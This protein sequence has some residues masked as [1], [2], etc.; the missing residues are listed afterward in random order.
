MHS[1]LVEAPQRIGQHPASRVNELSPRL[2]KQHVAVRP[3][4]SAS[5]TLAVSARRAGLSIYTAAP[6]SASLTCTCTSSRP[7][8][9]SSTRYATQ[10]HTLPGKQRRAIGGVRWP[11]PTHPSTRTHRPA[12]PSPTRLRHSTRRIHR[13]GVLQDKFAHFRGLPP[14]RAP[15]GGISA[16]GWSHCALAFS[17][18]APAPT[19][20]SRLSTACQ[21]L[22]STH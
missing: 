18:C 1:Y 19:R 12:A 14:T 10:S 20:R 21:P 16:A 22:S 17:R 13:A 9:R 5:H 2:W 11:L 8:T 7:S 15:Q 4:R 3:L 6:P